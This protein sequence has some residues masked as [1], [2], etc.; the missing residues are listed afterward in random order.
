M[1]SKDF[2]EK[3][4]DI[5]DIVIH[6]Q[7]KGFDK[8]LSYLLAIKKVI[9][10][11]DPVI[12]MDILGVNTF[13]DSK[14]YFSKFT[15][16]YSSYLKY[17]KEVFFD[18]EFPPDQE[19]FIKNLPRKS[20]LVQRFI[21][22]RIKDEIFGIPPPNQKDSPKDYKY[23]SLYEI[24]KAHR[25]ALGNKFSLSQILNHS[26]NFV[27]NDNDEEFKYMILGEDPYIDYFLLKKEFKP[28]NLETFLE[29]FNEALPEYQHLDPDIR[30]KGLANILEGIEKRGAE[31][32]GALI[33]RFLSAK[34]RGMYFSNEKFKEIEEQEKYKNFYQEYEDDD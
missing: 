4:K 10:T 30:R 33:N 13:L 25:E 2:F 24:V 9:S 5:S 6:Y 7:K 34:L 1:E 31:E 23:N 16:E 15:E 27:L 29:V 19:G 12:Q 14:N 32:C 18:K 8:N 20:R 11:K 26:I 22:A 17:S 21:A 28:E 3:N